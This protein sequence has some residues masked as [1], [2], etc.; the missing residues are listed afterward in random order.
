V[1]TQKLCGD[2]DS[3]CV[4][5]YKTCVGAQTEVMLGKETVC[6]WVHKKKIVRT[7]NKNV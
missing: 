7:L 5:I 6:V 1:G 3:S 2:R 4:E